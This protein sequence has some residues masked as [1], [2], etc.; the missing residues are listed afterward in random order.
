V[1]ELLLEELLTNLIDNAIRY[2]T[3]G[4]WVAVKV[5]RGKGAD[6]IEIEDDGSGIP[7]K[8]R[9]RAMERFFRLPRHSDTAGSGLGLSIAQAICERAGAT[10]HLLDGANPACF[11]VQVRFPSSIRK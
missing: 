2:N 7:L 6:V 10:L 11:V 3:T 1:D 9:E 8:D 4:K 5:R